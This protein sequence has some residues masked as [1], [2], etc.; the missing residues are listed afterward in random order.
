MPFLYFFSGFLIAYAL[1]LYR[2]HKI[3]KHLIKI[4]QDTDRLN[5][6]HKMAIAIINELTKRE[7]PTGNVIP[8]K[9]K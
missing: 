1:H 6:A 9:V 7:L 4:I 3:K 2:M 5:Q 8:F